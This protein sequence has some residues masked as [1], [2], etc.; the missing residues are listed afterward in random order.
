[1]LK[2]ITIN[3]EH[4]ASRLMALIKSK[5]HT[6]NSFA[7]EIGLKRSENLYKIV[8]NKTNLSLYVVDFIMESYPDTD[9]MWLL[10]GVSGSVEKIKC[11][12]ILKD[13]DELIRQQKNLITILKSKHYGNNR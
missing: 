13:R 3:E 8:N 9:L 4:R 10:Y 11:D 2:L 7:K 5:G 12:E 6:V 1:M